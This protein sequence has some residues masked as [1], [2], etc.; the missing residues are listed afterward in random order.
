[1]TAKVLIYVTPTMAFIKY[2]S[3]G[4]GIFHKLFCSGIFQIRKVG[5]GIYIELIIIIILLH[6]SDPAI[7][8]FSTLGS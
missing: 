2:P 1:M 6:G 8:V 3:V 5:S 7:Y 4:C